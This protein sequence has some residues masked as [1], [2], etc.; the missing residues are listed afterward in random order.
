MSSQYP[1]LDDKPIDQWKVTDLRE[2]LRRRKLVAKG[3]KEELVK[4]LDEAMRKELDSENG[5]EVGNG[6]ES[7][8][9][10]SQNDSDEEDE[11]L[12]IEEITQPLSNESNETSIDE[13]MVDNNGDFQ[14]VFH[15]SEDH[16]GKIDIVSELAG[17]NEKADN[18][19]SSG[20]QNVITK[21]ET[22]VEGTELAGN[23]DDRNEDSGNAQSERSNQVSEISQDLVLQVKYAS[24]STDS[25]SINE[26]NTVK[27]NLNAH[28]FPLELED[29]KQVVQ[30]SFNS[31]PSGGGDS[32]MA[33]DEQ[34]AC[35]NCVTNEQVATENYLTN[36]H[37]ESKDFS[38]DE[39][40]FGKNFVS[41]GQ[42]VGRSIS[43][44]ENESNNINASNKQ[45]S[46]QNHVSLQQPV[47]EEH[48][49]NAPV[50]D[51]IKKEDSTGAGSPEKLNL[52][53]S[54]GDES[55]EEDVLEG[56]LMEA[57]FKSKEPAIKTE[58]RML[59]VVLEKEPV[60]D[61]VGKFSQEVNNVVLEDV[62]PTIP[63]EKRKLEETETV[64]NNGAP[65][66][67]RRWNTDSIKIPEQQKPH[68]SI[69]TTPKNIVQPAPH[70]SFGRPTS[71]MGGDSFRERIVPSPK[72]PAT[73]SL[74]IDNFLRPFTLKAVQEL[75][76]KTGKV[77]DFWMDH[78]KTHCY[79][80]FSSLEEA[81]ETRNA[82]YNLQWPPNGGRHLAAEF[83]DPLEV[84]VRSE[85]PPQSPATPITPSPAT[86]PK[87]PPPHPPHQTQAPQP[88]RPQLLR[89]LPLPPPPPLAQPSPLAQ[90]PPPP[91]LTNPPIARERLPPPPKNPE[92]PVLTLD[93][94][95]K[96][97]KATPWIYYL[98]LSEDQV[99]AKLAVQGKDASVQ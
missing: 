52:D 22:R 44:D 10:V 20:E 9:V 78:I 81:T 7:N 28:N 55:M 34:E 38:T 92:P 17:T 23:N 42:E 47:T 85:A 15:G 87:A 26:K 30:P 97:T 37:V 27:D 83:V 21:S 39:Q 18:A 48:T 56:K 25:V 14:N 49:Q 69:S 71:T 1:V 53:R 11:E 57:D 65:K 89:Q 79:V 72:N 46:T 96:K 29:I 8:A 59:D 94:L 77:C 67:Q 99:A 63:M 50:V 74:R 5:V 31:Y 54:S 60:L 88:S 4:R 75:L 51:S 58:G 32:S 3:L 43:S 95:F 40:E 16:K 41:D 33:G 80:T 35:T 90:P 36:E 12:E 19:D 45:G 86:T 70:R 6:V 61:A 93:D 13:V 24:I 84:K 68:L 98:P 62:K 91:P 73:T 82:V 64:G 2:E 76:A 66:R